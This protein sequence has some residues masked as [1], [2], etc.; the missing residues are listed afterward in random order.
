MLFQK[1]FLGMQFGNAHQ[2][3]PFLGM[4]FGN[5]NLSPENAKIVNLVPLSGSGSGDWISQHYKSSAPMKSQAN[6][7]S[8][9]LLPR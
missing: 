5:A 3:A 6:L 1:Q 8:G 2:N 7:H 9:D 4:Q